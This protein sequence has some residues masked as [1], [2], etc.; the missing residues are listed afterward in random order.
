MAEERAGL[1]EGRYAWKVE[2]GD[3]D[4]KE[5]FDVRMQCYLGSMDIDVSTVSVH[6]NH[7][8]KLCISKIVTDQ[9]GETY[10]HW[11][12]WDH[13]HSPPRLRWSHKDGEVTHD[14]MFYIDIDDYS[15]DM[16]QREL[17]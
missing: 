15:H 10:R 9:N 17:G 16:N 11:L 1:L 4:S 8:K 13:L 14:N 5:T 6:F 12:I 3:L 2:L 7:K